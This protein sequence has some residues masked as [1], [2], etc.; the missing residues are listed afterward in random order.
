MIWLLAERRIRIQGRR[1]VAVL[2]AATVAL[3]TA[4]RSHPELIIIC[5]ILGLAVIIAI[6]NNNMDGIRRNYPNLL[7]PPGNY[8]AVQPEPKFQRLGRWKRLLVGGVWVAA[9]VQPIAT[10][11]AN[12]SMT[13]QTVI[14]FEISAMAAAMALTEVIVRRG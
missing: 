4:L 13:V 8:S 2:S 6:A 1:S 11:I 7:S 10:L 5:A 3:A 14:G 12:A 9:F